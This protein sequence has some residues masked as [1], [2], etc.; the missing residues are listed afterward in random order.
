M[1]N[2]AWLADGAQIDENYY[3]KE[4]KVVDQRR[5]LAGLR[6]AAVLNEAS[7]RCSRGNRTGCDL[8]KAYNA[9]MRCY[10]VSTRINFVANR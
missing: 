3:Q 9:R 4:I 6:L 8:L 1:H 5:A 10:P 2:G 7:P